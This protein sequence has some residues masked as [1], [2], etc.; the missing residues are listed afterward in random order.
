MRRA[1]TVS[2]CG[3]VGEIFSDGHIMLV[4]KVRP[5]FWIAHM[6]GARGESPEKYVMIQWQDGWLDQLKQQKAVDDYCSTRTMPIVN[7]NVTLSHWERPENRQRDQGVTSHFRPFVLNDH[8]DDAGHDDLAENEPDVNLEDLMAS[9]SAVCT[10]GS[11]EELRE[12]ALR[13]YA[14]R[15]GA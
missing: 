14:S 7:Y 12:Q 10:F 11:P 6:I 4:G 8:D 5:G 3:L 15:A 13:I 9:L 2:P 1:Y